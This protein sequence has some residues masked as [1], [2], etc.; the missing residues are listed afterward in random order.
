MLDIKIQKK[1]YT[2]ENKKRN[3]EKVESNTKK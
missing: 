3:N 2:F 1:L